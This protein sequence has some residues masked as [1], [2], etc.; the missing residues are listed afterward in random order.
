MQDVFAVAVF[1]VVFRESIECAIIVS[2]L[3]A[4]IKQTVGGEG[5][6][7]KIFKRLVWQVWIGAFAGLFLCLCIGGG[8]I[9][10]F[11]TLGHD[12]WSGSEDLWE[13]IFSLI[14]AIIITIM[15]AAMLRVSKLQTK[16]Q[17]KLANTMNSPNTTLTLRDK[18]KK[19]A[20]MLLPFITVL[21]EG[22]EAVVFVGGVALSAPAK[23]F[24]L[25]VVVG[26]LAGAV[27]GWFVYKG[28]DSVKLQWFLT[29][30][31]IVLYLVAAG[32]FSKSVWF[33]ETRAFSRAVGGDVAEAGNGPGSYDIRVSVWHV[34]CCN[35]ETGNQGGGWGIFNAI[36]G[37]QNSATVGSVLAYD[38]YWIVVSIG[39]IVMRINEKTGRW[40]WQKRSKVEQSPVPPEQ[41]V[42]IF[43]TKAG[44]S[45]A[46]REVRTA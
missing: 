40:P 21:R 41:A 42:G 27:I 17:E 32:L 2:V 5:G 45:G 22:L 37:W 7:P 26:V 18:S 9:A 4:F 15:G 20:M 23:A 35:P 39:F 19:Y 25:P 13:G 46:E 10:A 14:A 12:I 24:P 34:N 30:S 8:M 1:F 3:L 38:L 44:E 28:G 33:F 43:E 29:G 36:F 11:Y 6:D 16:W 31:T